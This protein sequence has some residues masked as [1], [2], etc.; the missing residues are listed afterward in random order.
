MDD[1]SVPSLVEAKNE[2]CARLVS[3]FTPAVM[4]GLQS[5]FKE[6]C[7]ICCNDEEQDQYLMT[8]QT[9]LKRIPSWNAEIIGAERKR[10][11]EESGCTYLEEIITCVHIVQLKALSCIRVASSSRKIDIDVPSV[12]KFVHKVYS[13]CAS[14][15]YSNVYLYEQDQEPLQTQ[16][17]KRELEL[18][19]RE[20]IMQAVRDTMPIEEI[21][22]AYM[23]EQEEEIES[24]GKQLTE[25]A[26]PALNTVETA[27]E[28][29]P[30]DSIPASEHRDFAADK[31]SATK[32]NFEL[33]KENEP[34]GTELLRPLPKLEIAEVA[35]AQ[36]ASE[37]LKLHFND[38]DYTLDSRG[39]QAEALV[40]KSIERL[41]AIS[42]VRNKERKAEEAEEDDEEMTLKIGEEVKLE[43][44]NLNQEFQAKPETNLEIETLV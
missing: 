16:K 10:I 14:K 2:W 3:I 9:F 43:I 8:F 33:P 38:V 34:S 42:E 35:N 1:F 41:E 28:A 11:E 44:N 24:Q 12:D 40:P 29:K 15:V 39:A 5:I 22:K 23:A 19:I 4:E 25:G 18:L 17:N 26:E 30:T 27:K 36:P 21:L 13:K 20:G 32:I 37:N 31:A 6:A 7:D